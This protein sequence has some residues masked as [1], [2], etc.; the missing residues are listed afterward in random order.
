VSIVQAKEATLFALSRL[1]SGDRVNVIEFNSRTRSLFARPM[2][3]DATTLETARK[4]VAGLTANGGTEMKPALTAALAP[5]ALP[6]YAR[7]VFFLTDGAVGNENEL[8]K[9]VRASLGDR[10]LYTIAIGPAPNA[11]FIRKAAQFGRG[12][13]TFIADT[14]EVNA[15]MTALFEKLERPAITDLALT[16]PVGA[17]VYPSTLP[18]LYD[19]QPIVVSASFAGDP[20]TLSIVGRRGKS[21]WGTL[22][23]TGG[24]EPSS[25]IG[26]HWARERISA[27][28]DS[29]VEGAPE[30]EVRPLIVATALEH[31]LVS[32]YTSLVAVDVT[33]IAPAGT[34]PERTLVPGLLPAGLDASGFVGSLPQ[35]ATPA[36]LLLLVGLLLLG[37]AWLVR[38]PRMRL[39]APIVALARRA[40][41]AR[42]VC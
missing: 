19:G 31:H 41:I 27:L 32:K 23:P 11:W 38:R 34:D 14:R 22:L 12:T 2:P 36:P 35:T 28:S 10:R 25:G 3:V 29:I 4:F 9:L 37:V 8:L 18:D 13:A 5:E 30:D 21:A 39:D 20:Q 42:R 15:R 26:A 6:G 16:W 1:K 33:P 24:G 17:E 7:Q 40:D